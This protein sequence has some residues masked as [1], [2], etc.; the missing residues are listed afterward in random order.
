MEPLIVEQH[1]LFHG[2]DET[3]EKEFV[4][5]KNSFSP[6][7]D[8]FLVPPFSV[9]HADA[10]YWQNRKRQ[11]V[12]LGIRS[13]LG[14]DSETNVRTFGSGA[15]GDLQ[16][17]FKAKLRNEQI[18]GNETGTAGT[19][20]FDPVLCECMYRWFCPENGH[21]L[22][23]FAGGSVRGIVAGCLG[24]SYTGIDIREGQVK[25]NVEQAK[26][27]VKK[28]PAM[29][30]PS[31]IAGDSTV[32]NQILDE[33]APFDPPQYDMIFTC[34]P[35]YNL[36]VYSTKEGDGSNYESYPKFIA[37][38]ESIFRQAVDRLKPNRFAVLV[39]GEVRE[40]GWYVNFE[41]DNI[42]IFE[43]LGLKHYNRIVL[44]TVK[45]SLPIRI[46]AQFAKYRK[47]GSTHQMIYV[48][49]KGGDWKVIPQEFG[50]LGEN[51]EI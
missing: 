19:S 12:G 2:T 1:S 26:E 25:A 27:I 32:L 35:Y 36:E 28:M 45:G 38:Y 47:V 16:A 46:G 6:L 39:V 24:R 51:D 7:V 10:E 4:R 5:N 17:E 37:W 14:R 15:P 41:R 3:L 8:R 48:F 43:R 34:P 9:L 49:W 13:E 44:E 31:W 40:E 20:I 18:E 33:E 21:I 42:S 50:I 22:D 11:W 29:K 23:P 30:I